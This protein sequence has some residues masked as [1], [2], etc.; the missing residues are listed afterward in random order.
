MKLLIVRHGDPDYSIDS[1]TETGWAEAELLSSRLSKLDIRAFYCSPLGRAK[2]TSR[3][4][5]EKMGRSAEILPWLREFPPKV[6]KPDGHGTVSWDWL[7]QDWTARDYFYDRDHWMD[8]PEF[9]EAGVPE[10]YRQVC[11]GLDALTARHGYIREG[12]AYRA[13]RPNGDTIVLF[14]HFGLECVLLSHLLGI[15]PMPLWHGMCAAPTS[16]TTLITE[17]RREGTASFRMNAFG[18]ISHLYTAGREPSF[19]ARFCEMYSNTHERHD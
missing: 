13:E 7:P 8:A 10:A 17:E 16:V 9:R 11:A 19:S 14:C 5:L 2:D 15:S 4:T 1:L 6:R 3:A 18:D 12:N